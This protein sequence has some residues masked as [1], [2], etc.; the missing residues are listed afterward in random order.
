MLE[1]STATWNIYFSQHIPHFIFK[2]KVSSVSIANF[3]WNNVIVPAQLAQSI[4]TEVYSSY[5]T[6]AVCF[7]C[8]SFNNPVS[9]SGYVTSTALVWNCF[10]AKEPT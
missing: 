10:S 5:I 6:T 2:T 8:S 1:D 4:K 9:S 7:I 3:L